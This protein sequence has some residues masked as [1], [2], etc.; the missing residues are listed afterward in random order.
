MSFKS[1]MSSADRLRALHVTLQTP[2]AEVARRLGVSE[3]MIYAVLKGRSDFSDK[4]LYRLEQ[5]E[6]E[7]RTGSVREY[8]AD[9]VTA[10]AHDLAELKEIR[11]DL[12][13]LAGRVEKLIKRMEPK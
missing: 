2:W 13:A 8:H 4:A 10:R 3:P 6:A 5:L 11:T 1:T 7:I 12:S 9:Y